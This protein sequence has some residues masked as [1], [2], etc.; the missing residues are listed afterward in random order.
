MIIDRLKQLLSPEKLGIFSSI[1]AIALIITAPLWYS[2]TLTVLLNLYLHALP[3][4]AIGVYLGCYP[5]MD[6][7][8]HSIALV[9]I[10]SSI[11]IVA[12]VLPQGVGISYLAGTLPS[13]VL[14][15]SDTLAKSSINIHHISSLMYGV[16]LMHFGI[17][18]V[19]WSR[20]FNHF[21]LPFMAFFLS[22]I[23][24]W[25]I[26]RFLPKKMSQYLV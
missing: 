25:V 23:A 9:G 6:L 26:K 13:L 2:E 4:V 15:R 21:S 11:A 20:G 5:K 3:A 22:A 14:L 24:T 19:L 1:L 12:A 7:K 10:V 17:M 8:P 16:Y 18:L